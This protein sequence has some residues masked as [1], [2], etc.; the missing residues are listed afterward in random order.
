MICPQA[1]KKDWTCN[2]TCEQVQAMRKFTWNNSGSFYFRLQAQQIIF[3]GNF[4]HTIIHRR[5][6]GENQGAFAEVASGGLAKPPY[7]CF[8]QSLVRCRTLL[9][10]NCIL[11]VERHGRVASLVR[12]NQYLCW[13]VSNFSCVSYKNMQ[14]QLIEHSLVGSNAPTRPKILLLF[15]QDWTNE[16]EITRQTNKTIQRLLTNE[17]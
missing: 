10:V 12:P 2:E 7:W 4:T 13:F 16:M 5:E 9:C 15:N 6:K 17:T 1:Y 11:V 14:T 3:R 8:T